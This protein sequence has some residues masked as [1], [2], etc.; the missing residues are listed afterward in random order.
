[1]MREIMEVPFLRKGISN[2]APAYN[3]VRFPL[4]RKASGWALPSSQIEVLDELLDLP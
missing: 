2:R 1:M 3:A 4:R